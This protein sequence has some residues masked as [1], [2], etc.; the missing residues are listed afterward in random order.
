MASKY[1]SEKRLR[2]KSELG[3]LTSITSMDAQCHKVI[4]SSWLSISIG[5]LFK[6]L[7]SFL[8]DLISQW[9]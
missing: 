5:G 8:E 1:K 9:L 3:A 4:V 7:R 2:E 6:K